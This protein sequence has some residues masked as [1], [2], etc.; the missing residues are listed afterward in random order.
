M[1]L[2]DRFAEQVR[3][4]PNHTALIQTE[5]GRERTISYQELDLLS[6]RVSGYL[7][8]LELRKG[9]TV[10]VFESMSINLYALLIAVWRIG[11]VAMFIDPSGGIKLLNASCLVGKPRLFVA[12]NRA[13]LFRLISTGV[14]AIPKKVS[15]GPRL[16]PSDSWND[17]VRNE[18]VA[19]IESLDANDPALY[20]FTSG[21]TGRPK[22]AIRTHGLLLAQHDALARSI[23]L[24]PGEV[25]LGTLPIFALANL[26]S[27]LTTVI[28]D[29][30]LR[31]PGFIAPEKV[32]NQIKR[33]TPSRCTASP[34]FLMRLQ[35]YAEQNGEILP[36]KKLYTG[37]APVFPKY[38]KALDRV[39]REASINVVFGSTE[40]EPISHIALDE[41]D[42]SDFD[43]MVR[44]R[45]L[46]VGK[47]TAATQVKII[48]DKV[49]ESLFELLPD[50]FES[51]EIQSGKVGEIVVTGKHVLTGYLQGVGDEENKI[52]VGGLVW[53]RTGDAGYFDPQGRLWLVGRC[54][55]K[56]RFEKSWVYP[57]S[58]ETAASMD[59]RVKWSAFLEKDGRRLLAVELASGVNDF[60][61]RRLCIPKNTVEKIV[62]VKRIPLDKRHN[63]KI[64]YPA[65]KRLLR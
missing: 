40:A 51:I 60:D 35:E 28:P 63:A 26:A 49:G 58:I 38:L 34:T 33:H 44:G 30:D 32:L 56:V 39:T 3:K 48:A 14:R 41:I 12:R 31:K 1:N 17:A 8:S 46:L 42:H 16:L 25:D 19:R 27:G 15:I 5:G 65:L 47:P 9:D 21:S 57:F 36:F 64:D 43:A 11:A 62:I 2:V 18:A 50:K 52:H 45:G 22:A 59:E 53:H 6:S 10:L 24:L 7:L 37:G 29:C 20:T 54:S 55:S 61:E 4:A 13:H 23:D